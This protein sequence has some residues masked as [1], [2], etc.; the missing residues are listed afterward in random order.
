MPE[1]FLGY[2][3]CGLTSAFSLII[4]LALNERKNQQRLRVIVKTMD[5]KFVR[6]L[7]MIK[8]YFPDP[9]VRKG[10]EGIFGRSVYDIVSAQ[11][12]TYN[13]DQIIAKK[14]SFALCVKVS[15]AKFVDCISYQIACVKI[16]KVTEEKEF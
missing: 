16:L 6:I 10:F 4:I 14:I 12:K 9:K 8:F 11:A 13:L 1:N 2:L 7:V 3:V 5:G 15:L